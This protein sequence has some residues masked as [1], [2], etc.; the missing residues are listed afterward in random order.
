MGLNI[1]HG[2]YLSIYSQ[3]S[4]ENTFINEMKDL[5]LVVLRIYIGQQAPQLYTFIKE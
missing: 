2:L 5:Q 1:Y 3:L 4:I